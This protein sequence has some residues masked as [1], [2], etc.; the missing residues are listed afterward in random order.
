MFRMWGKLWKDH[1]L[2]ADTIYEDATDANRTRK[3][4][5]GLEEICHRLDLAVPV[6][7]DANTRDFA[8]RARTCFSHDNF[9][10]EIEFDY[11]EIQV[12]EEDQ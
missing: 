9:I 1:H 12:I 5:G 2:L 6:W 4:L 11:L 8:Q 3:V 7:L 10:E